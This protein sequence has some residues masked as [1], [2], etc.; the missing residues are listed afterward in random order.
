MDLEYVRM[1]V[2]CRVHQ[3]EYAVCIPMAAPQ[4]YVNTSGSLAT[5]SVA[6]VLV[7]CAYIVFLADTI[8]L[9]CPIR[10]V[11]SRSRGICPPSGMAGD[12]Y[13]AG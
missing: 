11:V 2:I 1:Y 9:F 10:M 13:H 5:M 8:Q 7:D 6:P 4:E 3:A 12:A